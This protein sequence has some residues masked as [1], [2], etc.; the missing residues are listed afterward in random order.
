MRFPANVDL[1]NDPNVFIAD[2]RATVHSTSSDLGLIEVPKGNPSDTVTMG[3]GGQVAAQQVGKLPGVMCDLNGQELDAATMD[4][5]VHVPGAQYN[6]FSLSRMIRIHGWA[7]GGNDKAIWIE[8]DGKQVRF[9]IIILTPKGA[10]YAC[11]SRGVE[12]W[13]WQPQARARR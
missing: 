3:N 12:K 8:K 7:L 4:K 11:T 5:V 9:D 1:L 2:T 10:L 13:L 6:L